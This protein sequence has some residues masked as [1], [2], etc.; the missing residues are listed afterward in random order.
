MKSISQT[1]RSLTFQAKKALF[2]GK[3]KT[4]KYSNIRIKVRESSI[5]SVRYL[6]SYENV[7]V[8]EKRNTRIRSRV[9]RVSNV[10]VWA[11][12]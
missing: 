4:V 11:Y 5:F 6:A 9:P 12:C 10:Y 7:S 2:G 3:C 1:S 8:K